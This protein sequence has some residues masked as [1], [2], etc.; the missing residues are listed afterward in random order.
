MIEKTKA[1]LMWM[2]ERRD[3]LVTIA[4]AL[5]LIGLGLKVDA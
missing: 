3:A 5:C 2:H 1:V 4:G